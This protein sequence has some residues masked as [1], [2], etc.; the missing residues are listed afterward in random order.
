MA[1]KK[2]PPRRSAPAWE[3][4][5]EDWLTAKRVGR[6]RGDPGHAERARRADLRRWAAAINAVQG[7]SVQVEAAGSLAGWRFV[8]TELGDVDTL[9]RA[10][11]FLGDDLSGSSRQRVL[12]TLRGFCSYLVRRALLAHDPTDAEELRVRADANDDVRAF[13]E[14]D[15]AK[16]LGVA[17]L[18]AP[19][20]V[21]S[22]WPTRDVAVVSTLACCGLRVSELCAMTIATID[23][24][25]EEALLRMRAGAKGG[26]S[27]I[28]PIP[29]ATLATIDAY[30]DERSDDRLKPTSLVFVRH[31]SDGMN[32]QF[33]DALLRRL[34]A[35]AEVSAPDGAMAHGLRHSYGMR[36]ALRGVPMPQIQQLLGHADPRTTSIYTAAHATDLT[37]TLR[38]AG[39]M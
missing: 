33:V 7:R 4:A 23:R 26:R 5:A 17:G 3:E 2:A 25:G 31:D 16:L 34:V 10:L 30:L 39:L 6:R 27:R 38:E 35:T 18:D 15:I 24:S 19:A 14:A 21:R 28:V 13:T 32:Q 37:H 20:R 11:D 8:K 12:S 29:A 22:A 36:L 9:L 1:T